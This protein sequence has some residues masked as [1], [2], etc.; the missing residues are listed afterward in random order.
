MSRVQDA[1]RAISE[2]S[3][4]VDPIIFENDAAQDLAIDSLK[5]PDGG[6]NDVTWQKQWDFNR[7]WLD[8]VRDHNIDIIDIG[9]NPAADPDVWSFY[10]EEIEYLEDYPNRYS[11]PDDMPFDEIPD[12]Y[13]DPDTVP[14]E[15]ND[16]WDFLPDWWPD[17][18]V[19]TRAITGGNGGAVVSAP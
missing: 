9:P 15:P 3:P 19:W 10:D 2:T 6:L 14:V 11:I 1:A 7:A 4:N 16:F 8:Y 18:L 12:W 5:N 17:W 13:T